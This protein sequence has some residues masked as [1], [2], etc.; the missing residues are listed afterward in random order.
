VRLEV[1]QPSRPAR[2][3]RLPMFVFR[4]ADG[5][6]IARRRFR[7]GASK[8]ILP[9]KALVLKKDIWE[10]QSE[11]TCGEVTVDCGWG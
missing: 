2:C 4:D 3:P 1:Q 11:M 6:P 10:P 9:G 7:Y 5:P 8:G